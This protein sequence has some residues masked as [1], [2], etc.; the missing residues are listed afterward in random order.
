[1]QLPAPLIGTD[2]YIRLPA[3]PLDGNTQHVQSA[4]LVERRK[5]GSIPA[6]PHNGKET[7]RREL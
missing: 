6:R 5:L 2:I 4:G 7:D 3:H 1:M